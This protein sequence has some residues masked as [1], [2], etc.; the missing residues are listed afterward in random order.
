MG[1]ILV[2]AAHPDDEVLG[3]GG[4]IATRTK[5]GDEVSVIF[6]SDGVTSREE[7][8]QKPLIEARR[9]AAKSAAKIL[10]VTGLTFGNLPD[11]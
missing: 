6:L 11:N 10:G 5:A 8:E 3:C 4:Y 9:E 7:S 2:V 1:S